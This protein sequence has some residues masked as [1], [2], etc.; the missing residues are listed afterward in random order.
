MSADSRN[1]A[2]ATGAVLLKRG[3][4]LLGDVQLDGWAA[5]VVALFIVQS[6]VGLVRET[7]SQ[8]VGEAPD[9]ELVDYISEKIARCDLAGHP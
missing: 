2:L 8:L 4:L 3:N 1:D 9:P 7:I 5:V 6:G